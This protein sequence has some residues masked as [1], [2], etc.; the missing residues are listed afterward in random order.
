MKY[1]HDL[2]EHNYNSTRFDIEYPEL[3]DIEYSYIA[4][5]HQK[6]FNSSVTHTM[7]KQSLDNGMY[8]QCSNP[9]CGG[10]YNIRELIK[11][12]IEQKITEINDHHLSCDTRIFSPKGRKEYPPCDNS[13]TL[14]IKLI[15][16]E[17]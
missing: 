10:K 17:R 14:N 15:F 4:Y 9:R 1:N 6:P 7:N 8:I 5:G 12:L 11:N 16:R 3:E 2:P 13:I